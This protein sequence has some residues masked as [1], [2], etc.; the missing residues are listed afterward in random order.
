MNSEVVPSRGLSST[1][2]R[3][4]AAV[5]MT[6]GL[7]L[8]TCLTSVGLGLAGI[9]RAWP[10]VATVGLASWLASVPIL[11]AFGRVTEP[12]TQLSLIVAAGG[13]RLFVLLAFAMTAIKQRWFEGFPI[14]PVI[15][16][17][18]LLTI[19]L[20]SGLLIGLIRS[21]TPPKAAASSDS[22]VESR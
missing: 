6:V 18:F 11:I 20:E 19:T 12:L 17:F 5:L 4:N 15:A 22:P 10:A 7:V 9:E 16:G 8:A 2:R 3:A 1:F 14:F 13:L 21:R